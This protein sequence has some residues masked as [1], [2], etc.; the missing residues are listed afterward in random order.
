LL[1]IPLVGS[2]HTELGPYAL[3]LTRDTLVAEALDI[4]V[5]WFYRQCATVLAPTRAVA[6]ALAA[7]GYPQVGVWG[8]GVDSHLFGPERRNEELR[9]ELLGPDGDVLL[10]SVGR[11]S[12]EKRIGVLLDAFALATRERRR[13]RLVIAGDGPSRREL[14]LTAPAGTHFVG[15]LT[16][17]TL[18][19][20]YAC[21]DVFCF[22]STTDTFGQVLLE[23]GASGLPVV[24]ADAGGAG[25]LVAPGRTGLLVAPTVSTGSCSASIRTW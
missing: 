3:H 6:T 25:E 7:R 8:R 4:Y 2:Y 23:A 5:D 24:A 11:L 9:H 13:L 12:A 18:A 21:A 19:E 15:E 17:E 14:E 22:P 10:L 16:G 1:G 20:L